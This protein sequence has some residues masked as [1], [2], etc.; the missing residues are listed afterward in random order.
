[1]RIADTPR[2]RDRLYSWAVGEPV[3]GRADWP[4][5]ATVV[6]ESPLDLGRVLG[7]QL[8]DDDTVVFAPG[9]LH[10]SDVVGYDGSLVVPGDEF[11]IDD[12]LFLQTQEYRVAP[13]ASVLSGTFVRVTDGADLAAFVADADAA[14]ATGWFTP[15]LLNPA[16]RVVDRCALGTDGYDCGP[17]TRLLVRSGGEVA[18]SPAGVLIGTVE[19]PLATLITEHDRISAASDAPCGVCLAGAVGEPTRAAALGERPWLGRYLD[20]LDAIRELTTRGCTGLH[21]SGFGHRLLDGLASFDAHDVGRS[22]LLLWSDDATYL[23][24]ESTRRTMRISRRV[25][26]VAEALLVCGSINEA[27]AL[28]AVDTLHQVVDAFGS[29]GLS[30]VAAMPAGTP[31]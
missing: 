26:E 16:I 4:G 1:M 25:G 9:H 20:A 19:D 29:A 30:L 2:L 3:V 5:T 15:F 14:R 7:S 22:Q 23:Y 17:R 11:S 27:S 13:Y 21:V 8:V 12:S 31:V 28:V 6:L 24:D 18:T 10:S